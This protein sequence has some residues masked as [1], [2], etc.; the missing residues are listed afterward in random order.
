MHNFTK[1]C[2]LLSVF[3][4]YYVTHGIS[5]QSPIFSQYMFN[6]FLINPA[7]AGSEGYT[8]YNLTSRIQW[9]GFKDAP[10]T[11]SLSA[12]TRLLRS[13]F[14]FRMNKRR[15][16]YMAPEY[17]TIG[18]GVHLYTDHRGLIDQTGIQFT[19]AYHEKVELKE[20]LSF[21][22]SFCLHQIHVNTAKMLSY[23]P[24]V[25]LNSGNLSVFIP[26]FNFGIYYTSPSA[27]WGI[28]ASQ[29]MQ[30]A[31]HFGGYSDFRF[32]LKRSYHLMAGYRF[33]IDKCF[34]M[35]PGLLIKTND[36]LFSQI[37]AGC[38]CYYKRDLW[39]GLAYRSGNALI[40]TLGTR[41]C[42]WFLGYA[43][44]YSFNSLQTYSWGTHEFILSL[45]FKLYERKYQWIERF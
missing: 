9:L 34:S 22:L 31:V 17:G 42:N 44:D 14:L 19:F 45:K 18:L 28:S 4:L 16:K 30:S 20:Q 12:Q 38:R 43:Y 13:K 33:K 41:Y 29:L 2:L 24:D 7:I 21:G 27:F 11:N 35:E 23:Q 3:A 40:I 25:Y 5:Q 36:R 26:D 1:R 15:I 39:G 6:K 32:N 37:D 8:A 10:V